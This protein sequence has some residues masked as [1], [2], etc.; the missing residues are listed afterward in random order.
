M[1]EPTEEQGEADAASERRRRVMERL[2]EILQGPP[3]DRGGTLIEGPDPEEFGALFETLLEQ[4]KGWSR[5]P[6]SAPGEKTEG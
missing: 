3:P 6:P 4:F 5:L 2:A 1:S